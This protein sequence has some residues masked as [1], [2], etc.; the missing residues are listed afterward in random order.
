MCQNPNHWLKVVVQGQERTI[1]HEGEVR[2]NDGE[3]L[4]I[5]TDLSKALVDARIWNHSEIVVKLIP[6]CK[7]CNKTAG[8]GVEGN[9]ALEEIPPNK[10]NK[11]M[12]EFIVGM[13]EALKA[14]NMLLSGLSELKDRVEHE[15]KIYGEPPENPELN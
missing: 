15:G 2:F 5:G 9:I 6:Y 1:I 13:L 11:A 4:S 7:N 10:L 8:A 14:T 3:L 12:E